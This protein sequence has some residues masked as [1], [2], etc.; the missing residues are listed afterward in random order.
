MYAN[1][2]SNVTKLEALWVV[3]YAS[4]CGKGMYQRNLSNIHI[5][6]KK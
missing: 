1:T 4:Y 2:R 6:C 5:C 3:F